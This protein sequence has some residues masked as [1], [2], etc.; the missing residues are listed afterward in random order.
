MQ[1]TSSRLSGVGGRLAHAK[2]SKPSVRHRSERSRRHLCRILSQDPP[3]ITRFW[4]LP[5]LQSRSNFALRDVEINSPPFRVDSDNIAILNN[6]ERSTIERFGRDVSDDK[7][8]SATGEAS[9]GD[10]S[11]FLTEP[12]SHDGAS[13][14]EHLAHPGSAARAFIPNN[15]NV[16]CLDVSSKDRLHGRLFAVIDP[17]SPAESLAFLAADFCDGSLRG[18]VAA[19]DNQVAVLFER[20]TQRRDDLLT[21]W[22]SLKRRE[23]LLERLAGDRQAV[24]VQQAGMHEL[25]HQGNDAAYF[26][27]LT[28]HKAT[29]RLEVRQNRDTPSDSR[30]VIQ[31]K[32]HVSG[33]RDRQKVKHGIRGTAQSDD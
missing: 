9:V 3:T 11:H 7:A 23:I 18:E 19:E 32:P 8:V 10:Q 27:K 20:L 15:D 12:A 29:A 21:L 17:G 16:S 25:F 6:R 4:T 13:R 28:H 31:V 24:A 33:M 14:R 5:T 1:K 30:E 2:E 22:I 26:D